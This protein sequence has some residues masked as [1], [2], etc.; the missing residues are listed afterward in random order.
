L[1]AALIC[2]TLSLLDSCAPGMKWVQGWDGKVPPFD[3]ARLPEMEARYK[4]LPPIFHT[5]SEKGSMVSHA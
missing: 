4:E 3:E 2:W 1:C 5:K